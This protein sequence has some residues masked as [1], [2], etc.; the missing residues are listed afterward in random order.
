V[1]DAEF[2]RADCAPR[3]TLGNGFISITDWVQAG[4]YAAGLDPITPVGGPVQPAQPAAALAKAAL[5]LGGTSTLVLPQ[6]NILPGTTLTFAV[7]LEAQ[8]DENALGFSLAFDSARLQFLGAARAAAM[9]NA[10]LNLNTNQAAAGKL[11]VALALPAGASLGA[12]T[13]EA[14]LL[15]FGA[16]SNASGM[17]PISFSDQPIHREVSDALANT[18]PAVYDDGAI[19]VGAPRPSLGLTRTGPTVL[20]FWPTTA[21]GF[22]LQATSGPLGTAWTN[23]EIA[24]LEFGGQKLVPFPTT[25]SEKYFRLR[26]P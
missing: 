11:G 3:A 23:V 12:G 14:V 6:T 20:L 5:S 22:V 2:Q 26:Q 4:R 7:R 16:A 15:T 18:L 10:V 13:M 9:S 17:A 24:P 1:S 19:L 21:T 25:G 8:G